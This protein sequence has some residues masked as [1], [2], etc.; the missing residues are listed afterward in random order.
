MAAPYM[1]KVF[2]KFKYSPGDPAYHKLA[3]FV[4]TVKSGANGMVGGQ[5]K[6]N[7]KDRGNTYT[8]SSGWNIFSMNMFAINISLG[9]FDGEPNP[10][11]II[12]LF[13][14]AFYVA[15]IISVN[16]AI[17][18]FNVLVLIKRAIFDEVKQ[19]QATGRVPQV[20]VVQHNPLHA[21]HQPEARR[22]P[23]PPSHPRH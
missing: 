10:L 21:V 22:P 9:G 18:V 13:I 15:L 4:D 1:S 20:P 7:N 14:V 17:F 8:L 23:P 16:V 12:V 3:A 19:A 11:L 5:N 6:N 2:K